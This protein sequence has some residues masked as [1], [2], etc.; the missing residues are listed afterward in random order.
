MLIY[1]RLVG[2][3]SPLYGLPTC[4][5][6]FAKAFADLMLFSQKYVCGPGQALHLVCPEHS[7]HDLAR[8]QL[9]HQA[10]G[11]FHCLID[12][13]HIPPADLLFRLLNV[14]RR[15]DGD[16]VS[17]VY[18]FRKPP[19]FPALWNFRPGGGHDHVL[20]PKGEI[21]EVDCAGTGCLL[22]RTSVYRRIWDELGEEPFSRLEFERDGTVTGEDFAFARRLQ[23]L[24]IRILVDPRIECPHIE[25]VGRTVSKDFDPEAM[26]WRSTKTTARGVAA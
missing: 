6:A 19:Y 8:N 4:H 22:I 18:P 2:T 11:E 20:P 3:V 26:G 5:T 15:Y 14:M 1:D 24:G 25:E 16:V 17:G 9:A 23:R 21:S 7:L 13:D 12:V 10:V